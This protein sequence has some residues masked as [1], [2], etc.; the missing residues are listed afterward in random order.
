LFS[1]YG[2]EIAQVRKFEQVGRY[3]GVLELCKKT[4][5]DAFSMYFISD[6]LYHGR[7][8]IKQNQA[9]GRES[10]Q[11]AIPELTDLAEKGN[12]DAQYY[13]GRCYEYGEND[14]KSARKW[15][16]K[17]ADNGNSDAMITAAMFIAKRRGGGKTDPQAVMTYIQKAITAGNP[18]GKALLASFHLEGRK[19]IEKGIILAKEAAE[20]KS[21]LGQ[22]ILGGIYLRGIGTVKRDEEKA[23]E[24]FQQSS[25]QGNSAVNEVL[26]QLKKKLHAND[27]KK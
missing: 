4:P 7:K 25:D 13:L 27:R 14:S 16:I 8:G 18:D 22:M 23:L 26:E 19:D 24:F 11:K 12:I 17:A 9:L 3:T 6:Y 21:P 1:A 20:Q 2:L 5:E 10:Y 15:Y